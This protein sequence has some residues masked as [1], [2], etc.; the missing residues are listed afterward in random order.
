MQLFHSPTSPYVRK[1]VVLLRETGQLGDVE[2][3]AAAGS[4][5]DASKMPVAHNPLGKIPALVPDDGPAIYDS[6]VIC[7]YLD[8]RAGGGFYPAAPRLWQCL[9]L[10]ALADGMT[11]AAILM[12]YEARLRSAD[13]RHD[14]WV[15]GQWGKIAR[16]L[17]TLEGDWIT[18]LG[19]G[20]DI[21]QMA[22]G[23]A[24]EYL[25]FR[26]DGRNWRNGHDRLAAWQA[27]FA[28]RDSMVAT[29]PVE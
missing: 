20:L 1:V 5:L 16:A 13:K 17:D 23:C 2:M 7:R 10:E 22:L 27:E 21:G 4:P 29:R 26:H 15:E 9:T 14:G 11:D 28:E 8:D 25:D 19:G 18:Y 12:V 3:L 24:L 6:R